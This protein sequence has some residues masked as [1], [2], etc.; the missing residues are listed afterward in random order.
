MSLIMKSSF[1]SIT[2]FLNNRRQA[3]IIP[4]L[5]F[6][7]QFNGYTKKSAKIS[8]YSAILYKNNV[9][10]WSEA[11]NLEYNEVQSYPDYM[12]L[13]VGLNKAISFEI[14]ELT[15]ESD[16]F[17]ITKEM[18]EHFKV[19]CNNDIYSY[20]KSA[21]DLKSK[22][23]MITFNHIYRDNNKKAIDLCNQKI[24]EIQKSVVDRI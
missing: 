21:K 5:E 13:I 16:S 7:L 10:I 22:F 8:V 4:K 2:A 12:G 1:S 18:N 9:E 6:L 11:N 23:K 20:Y 24:E 17:L 19:N 3:K 14:K 15:V